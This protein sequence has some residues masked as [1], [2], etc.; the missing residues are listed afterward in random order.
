M[1]IVIDTLLHC[2]SVLP[3]IKI[4]FQLFATLPV[5]SG[6]SEPTFSTL[7][8]LIAYLRSNK[9]EERL[10]GLALTNIYKIEILSEVEVIKSFFKKALRRMQLDDW[11]MYK[12]T[13]ML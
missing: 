11:T 9:T 8:R 13:V 12:R 7:K 4:L 2:T 6:T 10:N 3:N 1:N 5:T